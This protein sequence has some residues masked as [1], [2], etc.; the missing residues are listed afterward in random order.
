MKTLGRFFWYLIPANPIVVRIVQGGS[1]RQRDLWARMGYLG[2]LILLVLIGMMS[3]EAMGKDATLTDLS[4]S[5]TKVFAIVAYGQVVGVCLLAPL[6]MAGAI[7]Q[8]RQGETFDILLT[9]P[10]SNLQIVLGSLLSRL[11][12]VIALLLSGLPL[13]AILLVFG[14]VP[15]RSVFV[16][17]SVAACTAV[18]VGS[19]A[20]TLSVLRTG[21][22]KAVYVFIICIAGYLV[23]T[24]AI[25]R[26][27][28]AA[29]AAT[30]SATGVRHVTF[31]TPLHPLL[32]LEASFNNPGYQPYAPE[33]VAD[34][35]GPIAFYYC[36]PLGAFASMAVIISVLLLLFSATQVR[37]I[38]TGEPLVPLPPR[39]RRALRLAPAGERVRPPRTVSQNPIAWK[40][41]HARGKVAL[42]IIAKWGF[43]VLGL[44]GAVVLVLMFENDAL[45][46]VASPLGG[47]AMDQGPAFRMGLT[48]LLLLEIAIIAMVAIYMSAGCVSKEREDGTLDLLLT[49]PITPQQY[50]WGKLRGLVMFLST[51]IAVP[52][53]TMAIA[54]VYMSMIGDRAN[55]Q[56]MLMV[57]GQ[58]ASVKVRLLFPEAAILLPMMLVPFVA[59]CVA[60]GMRFSISRNSVL[61]A[62]LP[63]VGIMG[64]LA[65]VFG[66]CGMQ[67][68]EKIAMVGPIINAFSPATNVM[69]LV[70]PWQ[71]AG[72]GDSPG[73]GRANLFMAALIAAAAYSG[74]V[75]SILTATV[76]GFD[77]TVRRLSGTG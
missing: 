44:V 61:G 10:L 14:G 71:V 18:L 69:M 35:W 26:M 67:A 5:G 59:L 74:I 25:D 58:A 2:A 13:F 6:F 51:M 1:R 15:V 23:G 76:R 7:N 57:S 42:G 12:F 32:V 65:L 36:D 8:E 4:K 38:G 73:A 45:P 11:F 21:G 52:V 77:Q 41:S 43:V 28:R 31:V 46:R 62:V 16:A 37:R 27:A 68:A 47:Q 34:E 9:T 55:V 24:Y 66:F 64:V 48:A 63:S 75:W 20:I 40:E 22:R 54:A 17:F 50:V 60:V 33:D 19:I 3:G 49:T 70:D 72:F 39:M 53:L 30:A 29:E 56:H